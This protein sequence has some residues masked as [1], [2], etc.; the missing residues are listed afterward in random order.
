MTVVATVGEIQGYGT[1]ILRRS[2]LSRESM[3][4]VRVEDR[5]LRVLFDLAC[6]QLHYAGSCQR[7]GRCMRLA[8]LVDGQWAGGI[9]LGSTFPNIRCR[10]DAFGLTKHVSDWKVRGL[11]N[12][13]ARENDLY[14]QNLQRI[15]N[16]AR[17]F[18]FPVFAGRG[19]AIK[20]HGLLLTEGSAIW[21][22]RYGPFNGFDTLCTEPKSKLF[23]ANGWSL[24]G[25]TQGFSR[26]P[27]TVLSRRAAGGSIEGVAD[28][29]GLT[30]KKGA[31]R[32]W[33]WVRRL[34]SAGIY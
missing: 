26:D 4:F 3:Q 28:N 19:M 21:T 2:S 15:V 10:D 8:I 13:W 5:Q 24:V 20:A 18:I 7:V 17:T 16:H 12:P 31:T 34:D 29:A 30:R 9:V 32:W 33:V 23:L 14:W 27:S 1:F 22:S 11:P 6:D 25:R